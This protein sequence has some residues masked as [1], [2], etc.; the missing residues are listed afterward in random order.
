[1]ARYALDSSGKPAFA[2]LPRPPFKMRTSRNPSSLS[3]RA[4]RALVISSGQ[5]QYATTTR[6]GSAGTLPPSVSDSSGTYTERGM[7][8]GLRA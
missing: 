6:A 3:R 1:M 7:R 4:T 5:V 2:Q 8:T